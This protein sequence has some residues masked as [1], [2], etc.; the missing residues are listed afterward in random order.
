M[1]LGLDLYLADLVT[2]RPL[3]T[4]GEELNDLQAD[5]DL[6]ELY[7]RSSH[8]MRS[9]AKVH[10]RCLFCSQQTGLMIQS[11]GLCRPGTDKMIGNASQRLVPRLS[12]HA[13]E[14]PPRPPAPI[15]RR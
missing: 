11:H 10:V 3:P 7:Y 9:I 14:P 4:A 8:K 1:F 12:Y 13:R 15:R 2:T 6:S 5:H